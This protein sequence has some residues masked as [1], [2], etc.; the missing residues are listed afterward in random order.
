MDDP[1]NVS[2]GADLE[3]ERRLDRYA[4]VRLT[5]EPE[6]AARMRARVMRE[7]R[8]AFATRAE[9]PSAPSKL[10]RGRL[11]GRARLFRRATSLLAAASLTLGVAAG[12]M[13][14]SQPGGPLYDIRVSLEALA[15]P[16]DPM[17]RADAEV[18]RLEAR[19]DEVLAAARTGDQAAVQAALL[20]YQEI[21]EEALQGAGTNQAALDRI[22][23]ALSRHVAVLQ[24]VAANVPAQAREAIERN[25]D[26]AIDN[27][28]R[29]IERIQ[30]ASQ[31]P[32]G[33]P[34]TT[35]ADDRTPKPS[36]AAKPEATPEAATPAPAK[37]VKP[38]NEPGG[39]PSEKPGKTPPGRSGGAP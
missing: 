20:A 2:I 29:T 5:P 9:A 17:D 38:T 26:R 18:V 15:L 22:S 25:I 36:K 12:A 7:T 34:G 4:T 14:S 30:A 31:Q 10:A 8:L 21:A 32:G 1:M 24:L 16:S 39:P 3:V 23:T 6:A 27:N 37:T 28:A 13:A 35:P 11:T 33:K 19:L